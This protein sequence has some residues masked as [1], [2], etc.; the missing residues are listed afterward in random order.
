MVRAGIEGTAGLQ[1]LGL[2][3]KELLAGKEAWLLANRDSGLL[4]AMK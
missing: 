3:K 1:K 2:G 4:G